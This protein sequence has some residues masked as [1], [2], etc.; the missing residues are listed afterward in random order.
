MGS[1]SAMSSIARILDVHGDELLQEIRDELPETIREVADVSIE[2]NTYEVTRWFSMHGKDV[3]LASID[4][5]ALAER[6][7]DCEVGY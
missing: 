6:F 5:D 2:N 1:V 3:Q 7:P 4:I